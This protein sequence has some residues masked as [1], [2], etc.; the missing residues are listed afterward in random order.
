MSTSVPTPSGGFR[1]AKDAEQP[2]S[3]TFARSLLSHPHIWSNP[4]TVLAC[5]RSRPPPPSM[6]TSRPNH[7]PLVLGVVQ[8]LAPASVLDVGVGFGKWGH[9]FREY[10]DIGLGRY[11]RS[12]WEMR[13]EGIE[14]HEP[15]LT[16]MHEY[17]YDALHV[18]DM[19]EIV[20]TLG[21]FEVIFLGDVIEHVTKDDGVRLLEACLER[22]TKAVVVTTPA[23]YLEQDAVL[24]NEL[25]RHRA[26]W[27][28]RDFESL[29]PTV[30]RVDENDT[31]VAVMLR[32]GTPAPALRAKR[33]SLWTRMRNRLR[34]RPLP[35]SAV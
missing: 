20:P 4:T 7:I 8:Q 18:G 5:P 3:D 17:L 19:R 25:E 9:L 1:G 33:R 23:S 21:T 22:A 31:L 6:P 34:S 16:P 13:L 32:N 26:H 35:I 29:G 10:F 30:S 28:R 11:D 12:N 27:S 24:G 2:S 15:Y 14:G